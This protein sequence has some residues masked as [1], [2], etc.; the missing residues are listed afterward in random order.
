MNIIFWKSYRTLLKIAICFDIFDCH[1]SLLLK[2]LF[3]TDSFF[4]FSEAVACQIFALLLLLIEL[5]GKICAW[6]IVL[7]WEMF[8][9]IIVIYLH[10]LFLTSNILLA[11]ICLYLASSFD[12]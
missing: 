1:Q 5:L 4:Y 10:K 2:L 6:S 3:R 12:R 11:D 8:L 7:S 9:Y